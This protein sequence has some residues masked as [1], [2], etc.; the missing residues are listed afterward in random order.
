[1]I[2]L[3]DILTIIEYDESVNDHCLSILSI[4]NNYRYGDT[5]HGISGKFESI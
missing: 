1:M 2:M 4:A 3:H 5:T